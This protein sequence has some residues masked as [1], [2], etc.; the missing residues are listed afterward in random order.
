MAKKI[1]SSFVFTFFSIL[2]S[3]AQKIDYLIDYQFLSSQT[4][5]TQEF[6]E[7]R[8][9]NESDWKLY[10]EQEKKRYFNCYGI[11]SFEYLLRKK[12]ISVTDNLIS[13]YSVFAH[14]CFC[15]NEF[16]IKEGLSLGINADNRY[17]DG[18]TAFLL[19][20]KSGKPNIARLLYPS[21][22]EVNKTNLE[23][24]NALILAA[25]YVKD[26]IF[27]KEL[28]Q[29]GANIY[30]R[31]RLGT[32][33]LGTSYYY[34]TTEVF[35][36]LFE[37]YLNNADTAFWNNTEL[38]KCAFSGED[39][40]LL[41][42][43]LKNRRPIVKYSENLD[44]LRNLSYMLPEYPYIKENEEDNATADFAK[45]QRSHIDMLNI[46]CKNGVNINICDTL[47]RNI[48]FSYRDY[49][50]IL[51]FLLEHDIHKNQIDLYGKTA[52]DYFIS[53]IL[54]PKNFTEEAMKN[55]VNI[56]LATLKIFV[57][58]GALTTDPK[59]NENIWQYVYDQARQINY[60]PFYMTM[61]DQ[62]S[63]YIEIK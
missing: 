1:F 4:V 41:K 32:S 51:K 19:G 59:I 35:N 31:D 22:M 40:I 28:L 27:I 52:L 34:N 44:L 11:N 7:Q 10:Y 53:E 48:F 61:M 15:G 3:S 42:K 20:I 58:N 2:F 50:Q 33:A 13:N 43:I 17:L 46:L 18:N 5:I 12:K 62:Y 55:M 36:F 16:I 60:K 63:H 25:H 8:L 49:P 39:T 38:L 37:Y 47:A 29:E 9:N 6:W 45:A 23:N 56:Q 26:T 54:K 21:K 30:Q 57:E 14:G 24:E